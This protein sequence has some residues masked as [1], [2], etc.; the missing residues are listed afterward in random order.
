MENDK[1]GVTRCH[2]TAVSVYGAAVHALLPGHIHM[3][4]EEVLHWVEILV[5]CSCGIIHSFQPVAGTA[6]N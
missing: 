3:Q 5:F 1:T 2:T 4:S 6:S